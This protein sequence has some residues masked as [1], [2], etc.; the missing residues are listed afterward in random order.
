VLHVFGSALN[1]L[2]DTDYGDEPWRVGRDGPKECCYA[3][4]YD[5]EQAA[6]GQTPPPGQQIETRL[7]PRSSI[8]SLRPPL[9]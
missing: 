4:W 6:A 8:P 1:L 2:G 5:L 9:R 7:G 3:F